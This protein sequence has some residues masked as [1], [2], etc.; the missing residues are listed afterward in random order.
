MKGSK[1]KGKGGNDC[2]AQISEGK[3]EREGGREKANASIQISRNRGGGWTL[4][5]SWLSL[6]SL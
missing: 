3:K 4:L 1:G 5:L 6:V 2:K